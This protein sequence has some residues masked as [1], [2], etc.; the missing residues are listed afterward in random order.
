MLCESAY[1]LGFPVISRSLLLVPVAINPKNKMT[2]EIQN[3]SSIE[4]A[5]CSANLLHG[6]NVNAAEL[7]AARNWLRGAPENMFSAEVQ[8]PLWG[9]V[10][11]LVNG[12]PTEFCVES[13]TL[14]RSPYERPYCII[15]HAG[16]D[17]RV[18]IYWTA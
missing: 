3:I 12:K 2:T 8:I 14:M 17:Y 7:D 4:T 16:R 5:S 11:L 13:V 15:R 6:K 9:R 18:G 1:L 10:T